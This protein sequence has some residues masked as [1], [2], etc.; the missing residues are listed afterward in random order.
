MN[1]VKEKLNNLRI[2]AK[3][4]LSRER[5]SACSAWVFV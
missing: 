1:N 5:G 2:H 4:T 3:K